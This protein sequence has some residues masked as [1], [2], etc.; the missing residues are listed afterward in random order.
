MKT[1]ENRPKVIGMLM[2]TPLATLR[3]IGTRDDVGA[4]TAR[5]AALTLLEQLADEL[6]GNP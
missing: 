5:A 1:A 2:R 6:Q 4:A 3:K